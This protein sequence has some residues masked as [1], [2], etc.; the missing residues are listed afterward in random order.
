LKAP[1]FEPGNVHGLLKSEFHADGL[2]EK[3]TLAY[4]IADQ[5]G[6]HA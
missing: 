2:A 6:G 5:L 1:E 4:G 3:T